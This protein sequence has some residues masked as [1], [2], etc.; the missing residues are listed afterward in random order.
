MSQALDRIRRTFLPSHTRGGSR[1]RESRTYG[2]VRGARG[3]SRPYRVIIATLRASFA[4][5]KSA[6][7]SCCRSGSVPADFSTANDARRVAMM[8]RS[9]RGLPGGPRTEPVRAALKIRLP[10]RVQ[11]AN[12]RRMRS[13]AC[14]TR[15][16]RSSPVR[17][18]PVRIPLGPRPS[19]HQ[20]T[21]S[22]VLHDCWKSVKEANSMLSP[23]RTQPVL[24]TIEGGRR[25]AR[26]ERDAQA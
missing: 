24:G 11:T 20:L 18:L 22:C 19:L 4:A 16:W 3:N 7:R 10:P 13:S 14:D 17:A 1:M 12:V 2:S 6:I 9:G 15:A 21:E 26:A 8:T 25:A 23:Q 5:L